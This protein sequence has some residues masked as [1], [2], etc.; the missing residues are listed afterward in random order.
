MRR[1]LTTL[2][3]F[4]TLSLCGC[5]TNQRNDALTTTLNAY[6]STVRWGDFKAAEQFVD[7]K[8]REAHPVSSLEMA[9]Y[10]QYKV[11]GYDDG[12]GPTPHGDLEVTQV[13]QVNLVNL[14]TQSERTVTD[15]QTWH[16]DA[17]SKHWWLVS[18]LPD[19][20]RQ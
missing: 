5:A 15:H 1:I 14:N 20:S 18:G 12:N 8:V 13:V 11:S 6:A 7:P 10:D 4:A 17:T 2:V 19:I 3:A 16:Y 9:R